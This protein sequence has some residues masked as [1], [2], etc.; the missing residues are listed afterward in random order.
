LEEG[1]MSESVIRFL[2]GGAIV[3]AF[4]MLAGVLRP[5]SFAGLFGA[6]PSVALAT[7]GMAVYQ[8]I[9][10]CHTCSFARGC[11]GN[12]L[13]AMASL[14]GSASGGFVSSSTPPLAARPM[15]GAR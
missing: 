9:V 4:A 8:H 2:V 12:P 3:S 1:E 7:L 6:G 10:V 14:A 13:N 15:R 5:K 11:L